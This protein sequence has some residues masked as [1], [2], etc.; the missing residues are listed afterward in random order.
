M[1]VNK[2]DVVAF[3]AHP[4]DVEL[5][6]GATL[7]Q[8]SKL[9]KKIVIIDLTEGELGTRGNITLRYQESNISSK[10]LGIYRRINLKMS[11]GFFEHSHEN[12]LKIVNCIRTFRPEIIF[13][14]PIKDR[15]PDHEKT[16]KLVK[17]AIFLSGLSKIETFSDRKPQKAWRPKNLYYYILWD[18][19][20][21]NFIVDISGF[22]NKK[23][24]SCMSYSSQFFF[25]NSNEEATPIS[26]KNF[27]ESILYRMKD[28]GRIIG[29]EYGEG[30][31][32]DRIVAVNNIFN[33]F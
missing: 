4:D 17:D 5:G 1:F 27:K 21:P 6:V 33:L 15:H 18:I 2:V 26:S 8:L 3:G 13:S 7:A 12:L 31:I 16:S 29:T 25:E 20:N 10:I 30:F 28:L 9:G 11:D 14:T 32:S 19:I 22:E 24:E 23:I